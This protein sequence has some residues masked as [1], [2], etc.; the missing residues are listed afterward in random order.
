MPT[1]VMWHQNDTCSVTPATAAT[2]VFDGLT[3]VPAS[4]KAF[5]VIIGGRLNIAVHPCSAFGP[6]GHNEVE[7]EA[8]SAIANFILMHSQP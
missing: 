2:S 8:V 3:S 6:H 4:K 1:L 7:N 5:A